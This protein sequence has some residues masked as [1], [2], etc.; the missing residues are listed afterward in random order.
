MRHKAE[1]LEIVLEIGLN[2]AAKRGIDYYMANVVEALAEIDSRNR[3]MLF[4][5][6]FTDY[7]KKK[8][9]LPNPKRGNFDLIVRQVP[10]RLVNHLEWGWKISV[11]EKFLLPRRKIA[12]YHNLGGPRLPHLRHGKGIGTYFDLAVETL[13][14]DPSRAPGGGKIVDPLTYDSARRA[15][16]LIAT[17]AQ[18]KRNLMRYY[19]IPEEK[20]AVI[21]TGV[22]LNQFHPV[23]DPERRREVRRRYGLPRRYLMLIGPF[24]PPGRC[25]ADYV[26]RA[27]AELKREGITGERRLA[28]VGTRIPYLDRLFALGRDIGVR[29]DLV[30]T[31]YVAP[32]DLAAVYSMAEA[33][34]HP[35]SA[36]GF[37]YAMEAF[38]C[39]TPFITSNLPGVLE[40]VGDAALT[41]PLKEVAPLASAMRDILTRPELCRELVKK[42]LARAPKF[43][44]RF[45]AEKLLQLYE[46]IARRC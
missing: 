20:I 27:Y 11:I 23:T 19:R 6:F 34:V 28:F 17:G 33:L 39:G 21:H 38:A 44:Y 45:V 5:Y 29:E 25:N 36:E 43:S 9:S 40:A 22:N 8:S 18:T 2:V 24:E 13:P 12:I 26:L 14:E 41:V 32:E 31:G 46:K 15:D 37:G 30:S 3:Y 1:P 16:C 42:G 35:T 4:T 10:E 7:D